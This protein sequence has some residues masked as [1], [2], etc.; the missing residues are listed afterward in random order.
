MTASNMIR[1]VR[2]SIAIIRTTENWVPTLADHAGL[3][4]RPYICTLR[5]GLRFLVRA[6]TDDS[7][8]LFEIYMQECYRAAVINP[9]ATVIDIGA[10]IG[11]FSLLAAQTAARVIACEPHP[12]NLSILRKN[13]ELNHAT[14]VEVIP[15]AISNGA[16][17]ASLVIPDDDTFVGRYSLHPGRGTRSMEVSCMSL[18]N[19]VR[20][21]HLTEIDLIKI[22][23]Q[24]S[25]YEILY[26]SAGVL[27]QV[28]QIIVECEEFPDDPRSSQSELEIFLRAQG[29]DVVSDANK[30][31]A[32]RRTP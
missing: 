13:L 29:F 26:G 15:H 17:K 3:A 22:D 32:S 11:C 2:S 4:S 16:E 20:E 21:A 25:E 30:L 14:N 23:C 8:V 18:E 1:K 6:G 31:Y 5:N 12:A 10:N 7:R 19:L 28:R 24:G 27:A 9:G